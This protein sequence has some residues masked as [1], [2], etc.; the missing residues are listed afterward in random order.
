MRRI[1]VFRSRA[2]PRASTQSWLWLGLAG[3]SALPHGAGAERPKQDEPV[4]ALSSGAFAAQ[5]E[6][7]AKYTCEGAEVS[8]PLA[9]DGLPEGTESLVLVMEDPDAPDPAA[10]LRTFVHWL[11][12]DLSPS[13]RGLREDLHEPPPGALEGLNDTQ[14]TGYAGPCPPRGRHRY[15]FKLFA[16]D[17]KLK[18]I[19][20]QRAQLE[21]AMQGHVLGRAELMGTYEKKKKAP[22][23]LSR[24]RAAP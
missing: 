13:L 2:E 12:L 7:P 5:R 16:L 3:L 17:T 1:S 8:P 18:L 11:L 19:K 23:E 22:P 15:F 14:R 21:E 6:I 4:F 24:R 10:P 20:P 9:W